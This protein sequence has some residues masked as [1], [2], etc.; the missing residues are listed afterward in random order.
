MSLKTNLSFVLRPIP[1]YSTLFEPRLPVHLGIL[2]VFSAARRELVEFG[3]KHELPWLSWRSSEKFMSGMNNGLR[4]HSFH[5]GG[6]GLE[7]L[8]SF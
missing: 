6:L 7:E 2:C 1:S 8:T 4:G 5:L 3:T